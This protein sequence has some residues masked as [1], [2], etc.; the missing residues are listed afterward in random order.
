MTRE[1]ITRV[2]AAVNE[3]IADALPVA[4]EILSPEEAKLRGAIGLFEDQYGRRSRYT[5]S[6]R[7]RAVPMD[8][9]HLNFAAFPTLATPANSA[10]KAAGSKS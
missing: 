1:E 4:F 5:R 7:E 10:R 9:T 2:E 6:A 3:R 8:F